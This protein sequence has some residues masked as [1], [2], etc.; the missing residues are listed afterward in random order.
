[1]TTVGLLFVVI[2]VGW[3]S[4]SR[5][6]NNAPVE[7]V[8]VSSELKESPKLEE[9]ADT[10][11][12]TSALEQNICDITPKNIPAFKVAKANSPGN[13][14]YLVSKADQDICVIDASNKKQLL[15]LSNLEKRN[16]VGVAPFTVLSPD[17]SKLEVY[18]QGWKVP[19]S[20]NT[21]TI[22]TEEQS[23]KSESF[24]D[25]SPSNAD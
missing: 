2:L 8:V 12:F 4:S 14:I 11:E 25:N 24:K 5:Y 13:F 18:Y 17:F 10:K 7:A 3:F 22:R 20:S 23:I 19:V 1:M 21:N 6:S 15:K 9:K 16:F